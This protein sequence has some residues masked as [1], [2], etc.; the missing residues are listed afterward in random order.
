MASSLVSLPG[1]L[2][3]GYNSGSFACF[4]AVFKLFLTLE[5]LLHMCVSPFA[6]IYSRVGLYR[7]ARS[8]DLSHK[9]LETSA[10]WFKVPY[11]PST[12]TSS[13]PSAASSSMYLAF[14]FALTIVDVRF[15]GL[16]VQGSIVLRCH[17]ALRSSIV[18][19]TVPCHGYFNQYL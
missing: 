16:W 1:C 15:Y 7:V 12:S 4:R 17:M 13:S 19:L 10:G 6:E 11:L 9:H 3:G 2:P 18:I 14:V 5:F 8:Y